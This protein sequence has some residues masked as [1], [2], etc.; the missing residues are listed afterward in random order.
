MSFAIFKSNMLMYMENQGGI[1]SHVD[2]AKKLTMEYDMAIRR[3]YQIV[4]SVS[5]AK[6]NTDMMIAMVSLAG[7]LA[8][9]KKDGLHHIIN[10]IGKGCVGYWTGATLNNFPTPIMPAI[11]AFQNILTT[12]TMVSKPGQFPDMKNQ[13]PTTNSGTFLDMLIM[14][15]TIHLST[16]EGYYFTTSLYPGFPILPPAPGIVMWTGYIVPPAPKTVVVPEA[17]I[18]QQE[19]DIEALLESIPDDNMTVEGAKAVVAETGVGILDD[20]GLDGGL[21]IAAIKQALP[22]DVEP[23]KGDTIL[24]ESAVASETE[25]AVIECSSTAF[26]YNAKLS[27]S[28]KLKDLSI[29]ATFAHKIKPQHGL[30]K[31]D[32]VCN[33]QSLSVNVL[34]PI[35]QNYP[36]L[37]INSGF[38]GTPSLKGKVSQHEIG[39]AMDIQFVGLK[40][41]EYLPIAKWVI[42]NLSFDQLIFEHGNSIWLHISNKRS[43]LNRKRVMTMYKGGY[44]N[45]LRCHYA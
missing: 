11:G 16:I 20:N 38:R 33:L 23:P 18:P 44:T 8:L 3:G 10:D 34:E 32:I 9:Q 22:P 12:S 6:P 25:N 40:P 7:T 36:N 17:E 14:A 42:E 45:G 30:S 27:D 1:K 35:K 21:T 19:P 2:F 37:V 31:E 5:V 26:N 28:V 13:S 39:E 4:N 43:G 41:R 24:E 15:M 29:I